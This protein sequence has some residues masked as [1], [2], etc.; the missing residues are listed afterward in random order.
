MAI[1]I[2][3]LSK[4]LPTTSGMTEEQFNTSMNQFI[5]ELDPYGTAA[6]A[7]AVE[8][9]EN[10]LKAEAAAGEL[11][12]AVWVSGTSYTAGEVRYSPV[13]FLNYRR[14]TNG[15]GTTDP[16]VDVTNWQLLTKTSAGGSDTT[17]SAVDI[18]LT[19][20]SGRL[21][22]V[23][24]TAPGKKITAP[25]ATTL[26][27]GAPIFVIRN[28]GLYRFAFH[29]NDGTFVCYI[30]PGQIVALNCS[31]IST[32]AGIWHTNGQAVEHIYDGNTSEVL[33]A[34]DSRNIAAAMLMPTKAICAFR[35]NSTGFLNAVV[36]NYQS[37]SGTPVAIN[38]E[39]SVDISIAAQKNNQAMV[40][41]KT[42]TGV[43]KGYVVDVSGDTPTPGPV[44]TIDSAT[45]SDGT[46]LTALAATQLL[47]VYVA[48][49][50][51]ERVLDISVNVIT[52]SA[53]VTADATA[54]SQGNIRAE[55]ISASKAICAF[56]GSSPKDIY[57]R[58]QSI[59]G[60][61]PAP[62]GS[63]L[64]V[65]APG[66]DTDL[67]YGLTVL[68]AARAIICQ[69]ISDRASG[70]LMI[71]LIDISGSSPVVIR[72]KIIRVGLYALIPQITATRLDNNRV[73]M[74]WIGGS[75]L[76]IDALIVIAGSDDQL[77]IGQ[78]S[79][80]LE[81]NVVAAAGYLSCAALDST[82]VMQVC[83]NSSTYLS[84]KTIEVAL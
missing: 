18:T 27:K 48:G 26:N 74:T 9:E 59:S 68:H 3:L 42:S 63:V 73:Y 77:I 80:M 70:D 71:S 79:E 22:I 81:S 43:T 34:V 50:I 55:K 21:Q 56:R 46:S 15:A 38:A 16:S 17:T 37:A 40:V 53:A 4:P 60:S 11:G 69:P 49:G 14:K 83:R 62:T 24:M 72:H 75:S 82:H 23:E 7:L 41:Y 20:T 1:Q 54:A 5:N 64:Q 58:L 2:P 57:I 25:V 13:D 10:A 36:L 44:A 8:V 52:P 35:N 28:A 30:Q 65:A 67:A 45:G 78:T 12:N 6:N 29:K 39:G 66:A 61:L 47:C 51:K 19:S 32:A 84:A 76:G 31:D 33:N